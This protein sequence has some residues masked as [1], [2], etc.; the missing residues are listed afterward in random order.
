[1]AHPAYLIELAAM[2]VEAAAHARTPGRG[3]H[4][5][6]LCEAWVGHLAAPAARATLSR[7]RGLLADRA[8]ADR[9]FGEALRLHQEEANPL[10]EARTRLNFGEHLRRT[11]RRPAARPHLRSAMEAFDS[12]GARL[13]ADRAAGELRASG[14]VAQRRPP[15]AAGDLTPRERQVARLAAAGISNAEVAARLFLSQKTVEYHLHK[16]FTKLGVTSRAD[17]AAAGD[18]IGLAAGVRE[19]LPG[20]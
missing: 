19:G 10:G 8:Q 12:L 4:A 5:L 17:L 2:T 9:Y 15:G 16:V 20:A 1:V 18:Q 3:E 7:C 6:A 11:G 14:E 13:L